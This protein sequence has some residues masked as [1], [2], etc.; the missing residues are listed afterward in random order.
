LAF[1]KGKLLNLG[2]IFG[3]LMHIPISNNFCNYGF[4][5]YH[6]KWIFILSMHGIFFVR[7]LQIKGQGAEWH[8]SNFSKGTGP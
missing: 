6:K 7:W 5:D 4:L 2:P 8:H 1:Q 3:R